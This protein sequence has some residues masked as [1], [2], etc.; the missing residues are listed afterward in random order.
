MEESR[1]DFKEFSKA[2]YAMVGMLQVLAVS[3][4]GRRSDFGL[5]VAWS[6]H[7]QPDHFDRTAL[8]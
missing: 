7:V 2:V 3:L 1:M 4:P 5:L 6:L 8:Y